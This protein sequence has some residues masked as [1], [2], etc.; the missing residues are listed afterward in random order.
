[1]LEQEMLE[2]ETTFSVNWR[3]EVLGVFIFRIVQDVL[4]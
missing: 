2:T 3:M 4:Q 1:M